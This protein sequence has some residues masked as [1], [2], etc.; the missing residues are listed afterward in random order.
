MARTSD[1]L[2]AS[3]VATAKGPHTF[4]DGRHLYLNVDA[5]HNRRWIFIYARD[6]VGSVKYRSGVTPR[7]R[8]ATR[9]KSATP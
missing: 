5:N 1:K 8:S 2:S 9:G 3:K 6:G 4:S 7:C